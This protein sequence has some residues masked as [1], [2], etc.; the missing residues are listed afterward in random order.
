MLWA[1]GVSARGANG[2]LRLPAWQTFSVG[3]GILSVQAL[4]FSAGFGNGLPVSRIG[5]GAFSF[6]SYS[7][8]I[9]VCFVSHKKEAN[10]IIHTCESPPL[11]FYLI[12]N[13]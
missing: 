11:S 2:R 12:R 10:Q 5:S 4:D 9:G 1:S 6:F 13:S 7:E 8:K 3:Q